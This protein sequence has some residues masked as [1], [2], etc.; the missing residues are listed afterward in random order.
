MVG[1][2]VLHSH[3]EQDISSN[4]VV[5]KMKKNDTNDVK[6]SRMKNVPECEIKQKKKKMISCLE[7]KTGQ[8]QHDVSCSKVVSKISI[9]FGLISI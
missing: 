6:C 5:Q 3:R 7:F 2:G 1:E 4:Y 9:Y 8:D